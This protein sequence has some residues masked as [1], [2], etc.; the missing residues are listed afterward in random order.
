MELRSY[1]E[2]GAV[3][4]TRKRRSLH[5]CPSLAVSTKGMVCGEVCQCKQRGSIT[6]QFVRV[7][8]FLM[9]ERRACMQ[10]M[11]KGEKTPC[12]ITY[13]L[14]HGHRSLPKGTLT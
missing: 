13:A 10:M 5:L 4:C 7:N 6:L 11:L 14:F 9:N 2:G 8:Q 12:S 1:R 3:E